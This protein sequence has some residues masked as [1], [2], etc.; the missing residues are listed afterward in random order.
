MAV[1]PRAMSILEWSC[2]GLGSDSTVGELRWLV[3]HFRPHFLFLSET[4]MKDKFA[5]RFMWSLGY[6]NSLGVSS[7]GQS[8]GLVLFWMQPYSVSLRG[9]NSNCIDVAVTDETRVSWCVSFVYG[10]PRREKQH[11]LWDFMRR[12]HT[13]WIGPWICCGDFNVALSQ[14]EHFGSSNRS[15]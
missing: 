1:L 14:D 13:G 5:Q 15:D 11:E 8:G 9:S 10:E 3:K 6:T 4:K 2:R 12:M 7:I